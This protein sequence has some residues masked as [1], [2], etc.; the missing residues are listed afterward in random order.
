MTKS[1]HSDQKEQ[2]EEERDP[3]HI[4]FD[5]GTGHI[6][7]QQDTEGQEAEQDAAP[8]GQCQLRQNIKDHE[9]SD[10]AGDHGSAGGKGHLQPAEP[11]R[12]ARDKF[13]IA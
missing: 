5:I 13:D 1:V 9:F 8:D 6:Q 7:M 11:E 3:F 2:Q 12:S 4:P 10:Q